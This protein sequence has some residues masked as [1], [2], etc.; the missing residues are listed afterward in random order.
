MKS[1]KMCLYYYFGDF[2]EFTHTV[3]KSEIVER[4]GE[5]PDSE[6]EIDEWYDEIKE[7]YEDDARN[8]YEQICAENE[9][10]LEALKDSYMRSV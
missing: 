4:F 5:E 1:I 10:E 2:D 6:K 8:E 3:E 7:Y 9:A